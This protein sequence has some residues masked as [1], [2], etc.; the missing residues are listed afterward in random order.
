MS[1]HWRSPATGLLILLCVSVVFV[2]D[3]ADLRPPK[4]A[5][6][7]AHPLATEA[8]FS[9][10]DAGGSA[11]DAAVA[12]SALLAVVEPQSSGLGGGGFWLLHRASDGLQ[13]MVDGRER[14][15][16][17]AH[18]DLYL[19]GAGHFVRE[20]ALNGPL[21]AG[22]PGMPAALCHL[23]ERYGRLP[24]ERTLAPAIRVAREG[25]EIDESYRRLAA[26]RRDALRASPAAAAQFLVDAE[27]PPLGYRLR[28][29]ALAETLERLAS[30]GCDGFYSRTGGRTARRGGARGR[31]Y[32]DPRGS[33]AIRRR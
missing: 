21:A 20:R 22:I 23:A 6:A 12:V 10:L 24:L 27:V 13:I 5:I 19:D 29:P 11:F 31:R 25:F 17:A 26:S 18:R 33:G 28:Q 14:A 32:L 1:Q 4:A 2:C 9:I 16:L 15:P 7:T 30:Q 8:G 3:A